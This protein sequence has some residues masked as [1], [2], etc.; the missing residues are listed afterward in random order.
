M[1]AQGPNDVGWIVKNMHA[2]G[3][4]FLVVG[5]LCF[6]GGL[7]L[8]GADRVAS[9]TAAW[10]TVLTGLALIVQSYVLMALAACIHNLA[11]MGHTLELLSKQAALALGRLHEAEEQRK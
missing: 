5:C 4:V 2:F 1:S 6:L 9:T 3:V 7:T 10:T 11:S 8:F